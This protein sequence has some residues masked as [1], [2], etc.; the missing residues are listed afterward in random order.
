MSGVA[1]AVS[2]GLLLLAKRARDW[3]WAAMICGTAVYLAAYV[4]QEYILHS[5]PELYVI[6]RDNP[7]WDFRSKGEVIADLNAEG[8]SALPKIS[9]GHGV[10]DAEGG[11]L[12]N[13]QLVLP[14]GTIPNTT[15][16]YCNELG[17]WSIF[18]AD[19]FGFRNPDR[20]WESLPKVILVGD[21]YTEGACVAE[22]DT[23]PDRLVPHLGEV[24]TLGGAGNG[25]LMMLAT[26]REFVPRIKPHTVI[27]FFNVE[28]D[29][30]DLKRELL[31]TILVQYFRDRGFRQQALDNPGAIK[32]AM[33]TGYEKFATMADRV[34]H[35]N[36]VQ[37]IYHYFKTCES[38][39]H[40]PMQKIST[41]TRILHLEDETLSSSGLHPAARNFL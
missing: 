28:N 29:L 6:N 36:L 21:S 3:C 18:K 19:R 41:P 25:P 38:L 14:L 34:D 11:T 37:T 24:V 30:H 1:L 33:E 20:Y 13:G 4:A 8:V 16:V 26:L 27:W 5:T 12:I 22:G 10:F 35:T 31:S 40:P 23:L 32:K 15:V 7:E 9:Y 39:D 2:A 17:Q